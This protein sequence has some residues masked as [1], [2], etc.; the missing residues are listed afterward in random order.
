MRMGVAGCA[1]ILKE[2][3]LPKERALRK[4][5]GMGEGKPFSASKRVSFPHTLHPRLLHLRNNFPS[6]S[7]H[8]RLILI[9]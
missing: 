2:T 9:Y 3:L 4:D 5:R 8:T 1:C 6:R 7:L